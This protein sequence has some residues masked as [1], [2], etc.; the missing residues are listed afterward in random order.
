LIKSKRPGD[1]TLKP[2]K[3][4]EANYNYVKDNLYEVVVLPIGA[5]EPH[6]LHLPY[7]NDAMTTERVGD[8][9]CQRAHELGA[10]VALLPCLPY[11]VDSNLMGFPMTM[12][13]NPSTLD[14][15]IRD[16]VKSV[17]AHGIKKMIILNGHGG[18]GFKNTLRELYGQTEVFLSLVEWWKVPSDLYDDL[19]DNP[20]GDHAEEMETS[21]ALYLYP[22]LVEMTAADDGEVKESKFEAINQGWAQ[23]T[24]PWHIVTTNAGV[25]NPKKATAAKG[26]LIVNT[27]VDRISQYI[28]ELSDA[29]VNEAFPY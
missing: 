6:N 4:L 28:K 26:E 12:S 2:W 3:L 15:M 14:L 9:I 16:L 22:E 24:R 25:G 21:V 17:E 20:G 23:I 10:K 18:N 5:T 19:L 29:E 11:G 7:G 1:V 27:T 13:V 8:L